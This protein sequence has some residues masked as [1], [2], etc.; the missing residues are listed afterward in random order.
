MANLEQTREPILNA[1]AG[2]LVTKAVDLTQTAL[3]SDAGKAVRTAIL[4]GPEGLMQQLSQAAQTKAHDPL[5]QARLVLAE[6]RQHFD[7]MR[8]AIVQMGQSLEQLNGAAPSGASQSPTMALLNAQSEAIQG[9]TLLALKGQQMQGELINAVDAQAHRAA[10]SGMPKW[11]YYIMGFMMIWSML[12]V[13][14]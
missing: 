7:A 4:K 10:S 5:T 9:L 1:D 2:R 8:T 3:A 6:Q 13:I 11:I 14:F 12:G